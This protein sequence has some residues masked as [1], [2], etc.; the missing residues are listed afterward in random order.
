MPQT[1]HPTGGIKLQS[2]SHQRLPAKQQRMNSLGGNLALFFTE[3]ESRSTVEAMRAARIITPTYAFLL[4]LARLDLTLA[5]L[6]EAVLLK[7]LLREY[8]T[9]CYSA[10]L[11]GLFRQLLCLFCTSLAFK[12]GNR[13][14]PLMPPEPFSVLPEAPETTTTLNYFRGSTPFGV[15]DVSR[16]PVPNPGYESTYFLVSTMRIAA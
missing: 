7:L 15:V 9:G 6:D 14:L 1:P 5:P 13:P 8:F 10:L 11:C 12:G 16:L 3:T 4:L 2:F